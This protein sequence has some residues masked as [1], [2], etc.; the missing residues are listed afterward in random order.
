MP[1]GRNQ[2]MRMCDS[3]SQ[4][5][6]HKWKYLMDLRCTFKY[7]KKKS[8][9]VVKYSYRYNVP[10]LTRRLCCCARWKAAR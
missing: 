6:D 3:G 2:G 1:K 8:D 9:S 4:L 10:N 7:R 5:N